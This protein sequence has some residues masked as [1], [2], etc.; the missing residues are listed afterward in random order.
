MVI[1]AKHVRFSGRVQG[2]GFRYTATSLAHSFGVVG[3]VRNLPDGDVE[4][5]AEGNPERIEAFLQAL[6]DRMKQYI[7][8]QDISDVAPAGY[9]GFEIR[10]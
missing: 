9:T 5:V 6:H 2:V 4:L 8:H 7:T 10:R 1:Q 3:W